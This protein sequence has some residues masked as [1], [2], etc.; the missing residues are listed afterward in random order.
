MPT[1]T[2]EAL[3]P[4]AEPARPFWLFPA[5]LVGLILAATALFLRRRRKG[6]TVQEPEAVVP[7]AP[8]VVP[9]ARAVPEAPSDPVAPP[10]VPAPRFLEPPPAPL[11]RIDIE[12]PTVSRAGVNLVTATADLTVTLRNPSSVAAT[13]IALDVRLLSAQPGQDAVIHTLFSGPV[14]RPATPRFDLA[15]GETK[16]VRVMATMPRDAITILTASERPMF[17][18]VVAIRAVHAGGQT[19]SVHAIGIERAGQAK[20]GPFWLDVPSRMYDTIGVRP[21]SA[22]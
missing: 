19:R 14:D 4:A 15:P 21:H 6:E 11:A 5:L 9:V 12:A 7:I 2:A 22:Q 17:V 8:P 18:P 3:P 16:R 13:G 1:V 10:V 20:L